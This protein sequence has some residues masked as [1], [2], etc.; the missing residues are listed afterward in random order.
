LEEAVATARQILLE[1][2][3]LV[4]ALQEDEGENC[5]S[6][7]LSREALDLYRIIQEFLTNTAR[8]GQAT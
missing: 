7:F 5:L 3:S 6:A 4:D 8:H 1:V 2:R